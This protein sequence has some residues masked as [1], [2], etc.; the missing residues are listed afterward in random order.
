MVLPY[1]QFNGN[2]E[3]AFR[4]YAEVFGGRQPSFARLNG[5]PSNPV[6]HAS[7][8]LPELGGGI[9]GADVEGPVVCSGMGILLTIPSRERIEEIVARLAVNGTLIQGFLP[10]PPPDDNA[11]GA[12]VLDQ[13]GFTWHLST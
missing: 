8:M 1:L 6:M 2:C 3:E 13:Y 11:G 10:H 12:A 4:F 7:L 5:D 9:S